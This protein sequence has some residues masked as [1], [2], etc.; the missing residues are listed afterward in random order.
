MKFPL[1]LTG[2]DFAEGDLVTFTFDD[3]ELTYRVPKVPYNRN[4]IDRVNHQK[5]FRNADAADWDHFGDKGHCT[6]QLSVQNWNYEDAIS[7]DDIAHVLLDIEVLKH[8]DNEYESCICLNSKSF[9]EHFLKEIYNHYSESD[10]DERPYWPTRQNNFFAKAIKR[11]PI[12]GL[13]VQLDLGGGEKYPVPSAYFSLGRRYSLRIAFHFGSL[14]YYDDR[15]NPYSEELLQQFK[16]DAFDDFLSHIRIEY[17]PE[18]IA[19]IQKLKAK[20]Q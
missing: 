20:Q 15:P 7:H 2:P 11:D 18:T 16:L 5:D 9:A 3:A 12:D 19:L 1:N 4:T 17:T 8:S 10:Q 13:Q 14:H 6:T